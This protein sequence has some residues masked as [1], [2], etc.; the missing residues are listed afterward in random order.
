MRSRERVRAIDSYIK[1][2]Y[3][4]DGPDR[5][6]EALGEPREYV[7]SRAHYLKIRMPGNS[8]KKIAKKLS[9]A[10]TIRRLELDNMTLRKELIRQTHINH[11]LKKKLELTHA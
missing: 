3:P 6:A 5:V 7:M 8:E 9:K 10:G 11:V 1:A 4:T 2:N